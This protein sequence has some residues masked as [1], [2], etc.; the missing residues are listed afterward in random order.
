MIKSYTRNFIQKIYIYSAA[1]ITVTGNHDHFMR[2][3]F[4]LKRKVWK[5]SC[6]RVSY[7]NSFEEKNGKI[8]EFFGLRTDIKL[9]FRQNLPFTLLNFRILSRSKVCERTV[10]IVA[11][12]KVPRYGEFLSKP[13]KATEAP[14]GISVYCPRR[15]MK[16]QISRSGNTITSEYVY[17]CMCDRTRRTRISRRS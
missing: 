14:Q 10:L 17:N 3:Q 16:Y 4:H 12:H 5:P 11:T 2:C 7:T 6:K 1:V 15:R 13:K 9:Q 8:A